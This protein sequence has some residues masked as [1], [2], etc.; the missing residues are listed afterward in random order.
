MTQH[1][2]EQA[3]RWQAA[4]IVALPVRS[5][6]SKAPG[7]AT[8]KEYQQRQPTID[9][10]VQWFGHGAQGIGVLVIDPRWVKPLPESL[11]AL[12]GTA[13]LVVVVE[14][15][16]RVGGVGAAVSQLLRDNGVE[17]PVRNVGVPDR[18]LDHGKRAEVLA[19]CGLTAQDVSRSIVE[20]VAHR[21]DAPTPVSPP[22]R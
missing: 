14:D 12:A 15:G 1:L 16:V 8:W 17:V 11:V 18:F 10:Y 7:L 20:A 9:E 4:G 5:D 13:R 6:G 3:I 21:V 19:E 2:L 22:I